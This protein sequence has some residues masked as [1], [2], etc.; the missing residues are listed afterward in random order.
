MLGRLHALSH[1]PCGGG[2]S[3]DFL[4]ATADLSCGDVTDLTNFGGAVIDSRA[5]AKNAD[6]IERSK[7]AAGVTV[8]VGGEYDDSVGCFV[9]PTV[10]FV[11]RSDLRGLQYRIFRS[12]P[13]VHVYPD[14]RFDDVLD[15]VDSGSKYALTGCGHRR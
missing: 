6:A 8:A 10:L 7:G 1:D 5:Y 15:I 9:R 3:D 13:A 12:D 14:E 11:G 2:W 4:S